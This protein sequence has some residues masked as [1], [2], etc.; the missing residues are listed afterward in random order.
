MI[1]LRS[2]I[3]RGGKEKFVNWIGSKLIVLQ[4][5][6]KQMIPADKL[7][8]CHRAFGHHWIEWGADLWLPINSKICL[9]ILNLPNRTSSFVSDLRV[10][11][12]SHELGQTN[13]FRKRKLKSILEWI[14]CWLLSVGWFV[15]RSIQHA[16]GAHFH[17]LKSINL[18][19]L[20]F[21][22][23]HHSTQVKSPP[24]PTTFICC[25]R[26]NKTECTWSFRHFSRVPS[27]RDSRR[28]ENFEWRKIN[29]KN[30]ISKYWPSEWCK[31]VASINFH[32]II[33]CSMHVRRAACDVRW[34]VRNGAVRE[35]EK[36]AQVI[37]I[38]RVAKINV[39]QCISNDM[40][41][42]DSVRVVVVS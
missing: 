29:K 6:M 5:P 33:I 31:Q 30:V 36:T 20:P 15:D 42:P 14:S 25:G 28:W 35:R 26:V 17:E 9:I 7:T 40:C 2:A 19:N 39:R 1:Q 16:R 27:R 18:N 41:V 3:R 24:P 11:E 13:G 32:C 12:A 23:P 4:L 10:C 38:L 8:V 34:T 37:L 22:I 21:L